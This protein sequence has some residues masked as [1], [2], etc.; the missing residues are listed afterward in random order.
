EDGIRDRNVTGVQ[1]CALPIW[2]L[3][4]VAERLRVVAEAAVEV[5]GNQVHDGLHVGHQPGERQHDPI[6]LIDQLAP[7]AHGFG[8]A[9]RGVVR[10]EERRVGKERM[11]RW[12]SKHV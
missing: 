2:V 7:D 12:E 9:V 5:S 10:S 8:L 1:T 6:L 3:D 11:Y 4:G